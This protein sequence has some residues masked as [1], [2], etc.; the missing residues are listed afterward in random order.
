MSGRDWERG[1]SAEQRQG[2]ENAQALTRL[3]PRGEKKEGWVFICGRVHAARIPLSL[4]PRLVST[5][6][7]VGQAEG[8][9]RESEGSGKSSCNAAAGSLCTFTYWHWVCKSLKHTLEHRFKIIGSRSSDPRLKARMP[10]RATQPGH[11]VEHLD[12]RCSGPASCL[13]EAGSTQPHPVIAWWEWRLSM[14]VFSL[15]WQRRGQKS[16]F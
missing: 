3:Y 5:P 10:A 13:Q 8:P 11:T 14:A 15:Q 16:N 4:P 1:K 12:V 9:K 7:D 6:E 2:D